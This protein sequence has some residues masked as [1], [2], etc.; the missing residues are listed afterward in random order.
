MSLIMNS[1]GKSESVQA[2]DVH[3]HYIPQEYMSFVQEHNALMDELYPI[4]EWSEESLKAF[5]DNAEIAHTILTTPAPHPYFGDTEESVRICR[6][7]NDN[8]A[9]LA[10]ASDGRISWCATLPVPDARAAA[11]EAER[12]LTELGA[13]GVK[14]PTNAGGVYLGDESLEPLMQVLDKHQTVAVLHPHKPSPFNDKLADGLPLAMYEYTA[15]TTRAVASMFAHNVPARY[16]KIKFV[17][18][19]AGAL[20]PLALPRMKAVHPIVKAKGYAGDIDW[21]ANLSS[22]WFDV[23]GSPNAQSVKRLMEFVP[24]SHIL[25]GSDFPY[26]PANALSAGL[27]K[28]RDELAKDPQLSKYASDILANNAARLFGLSENVTKGQNAAAEQNDADKAAATAALS[29]DAEALLVRIA[30]IEIYP[31]YLA[32]YLDAAKSVGAESVAKE[33]GVLCIFPMQSKNN[34][35]IIRILEIYRDDDAYQSHLKTPH[36]LKYKTSTLHMVKSLDL[37]P[38]SPLDAANMNAVFQKIK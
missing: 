15:E 20:L 3:S 31:D 4:P 33:S 36:F 25:Y 24:V 13:V 35:C 26:A 34:P 30:E 11:E 9:K 2:V 7:L 29:F 22:L 27:A 23:A 16:N 1:C 10:A 38:M 5:T 21:E 37:V 28:F 12:A 6:L 18:P 8:A 32:E 14:L 19:H 17:I